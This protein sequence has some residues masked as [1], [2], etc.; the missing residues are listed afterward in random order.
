MVIHRCILHVEIENATIGQDQVMQQRML[1][2][3]QQQATAAW[4]G[5]IIRPMRACPAL[6]LFRLDRNPKV[7]IAV[8]VTRA[9]G[10]AAPHPDRLNGLIGKTF[11]RKIADQIGMRTMR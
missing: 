2:K 9:R 4:D 8:R 3:A 11:S 1:P 5:Q 10:Q 7:N 6:K